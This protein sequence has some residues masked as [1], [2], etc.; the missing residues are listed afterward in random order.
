MSTP[1][2]DRSKA[3]YRDLLG[4]EVVGEYE[5]PR[6]TEVMN[7]LIHLPDSSARYAMLK[8]GNALLEIFQFETPIPRTSDPHRSVSDHG[9]THIAL[10]VTDIDAEYGRLLASGM[11]FNCP[12]QD[13]ENGAMKCTYGYDPDGN[14]IELQ[15]ILN[16]DHP[17]AL[18]WD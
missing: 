8:R 7:R 9:L 14:V 16:P 5:W 11:R 17:E 3:F 10:D 12:P 4:F 2:L 1:N 18:R 15:E 6:G 13:L